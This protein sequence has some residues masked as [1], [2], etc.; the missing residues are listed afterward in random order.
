MGNLGQFQSIANNLGITTGANDQSF[1]IPDV[2][3]SKLIASK[4]LEKKWL[5]RDSSAVT[6]EEFWGFKKKSWY[7]FLNANSFKNNSNQEN[8]IKKFSN[9]IEIQEDKL[10]SLI[11]IRVKFKDPLIS[12]SVGNF[13]GREVQNYIQRENSAQST[14]EKNFIRE[15]LLI[16]ANEL[17][18]AEQ[19]LKIFKER[20]RSY[21]DSPEL[22]MNFS[23]LFRESEA[24]KGV[25][26][27]LQQELEMARIKEVKQ[28]P[29]LHVLDKATPSSKKS[30]PKR[31]LFA[32]F[33]LI[34]GLSYSSISSLFKYK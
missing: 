6:L 23:R 24:K 27:T 32:V 1:N 16:V 34:I 30:S 29:I 21:E 20:N 10:T 5:T 15:R 19:S 17:E 7:S 33:F 3:K 9:H 13:I 26:L 31:R 8:Y 14:K 28:S 12:A 11:R 22:F 2:V 25:Y 4:V 18:I